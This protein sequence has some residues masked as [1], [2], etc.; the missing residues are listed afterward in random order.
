MLLSTT[1]F[2]GFNSILHV[3][4]NLEVSILRFYVLKRDFQPYIH[5]L[6]LTRVPFLVLDFNS[7]PLGINILRYLLVSKKC[8][9]WGF[10]SQNSIAHWLKQFNSIDFCSFIFYWYKNYLL[11]CLIST[12]LALKMSNILLSLNFQLM[13]LSKLSSKSK[14]C[15]CA[16]LCSGVC[17]FFFLKSFLFCWSGFGLGKC[18]QA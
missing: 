8:W 2:D 4:E 17:G 18:N 9:L 7:C 12:F 5:T 6:L 13:Q 3:W 10:S 15:P 11:V 16:T 14:K 1:Y